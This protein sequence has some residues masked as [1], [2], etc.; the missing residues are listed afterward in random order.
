MSSSVASWHLDKKVDFGPWDGG[1]VLL[2]QGIVGIFFSYV[3]GQGEHDK[4]SIFIPTFLI[5]MSTSNQVS[6]KWKAKRLWKKNSITGL[7]VGNI[8]NAAKCIS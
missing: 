1:H 6:A 2:T 4:V 7:T 5:Q 8:Y 3:G